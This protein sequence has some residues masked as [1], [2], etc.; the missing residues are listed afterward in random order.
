MLKDLKKQV[1][2]ANMLLKESGLIVLT[3]GNVSGIDRDKG[4]FVIKPSGVPYD[5]LSPEDMIVMDLEGNK[6]EGD[7]NP[8]SDTPTHLELYRSFENIGGVAHTH[9]KWATI[10]AQAGKGIEAYGTTHAD[11]FYGM[12]PCTRDMTDEEIKGDYELETGK[13]I[14]ET[15][16]GLNPDHIPSVLVKS[17]G[18]F[19]WGKDAMDAVTNAIVLEEVALMAYGTVQLKKDITKMDQNLLDKH[20]LRKHGSDAYYGQNK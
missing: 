15:F 12:I 8:S 16:K 20:F 4:L 10:W 13:V 6:V 17:H 1:Y 3:W 19:S 11:H 7:L 2:E 5:E 14:V 18:P 9:S